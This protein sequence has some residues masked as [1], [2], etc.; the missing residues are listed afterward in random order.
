MDQNG[1]TG[2][3]AA[4]RLL[5]SEP[6]GRVADLEGRRHRQS[7]LLKTVLKQQIRIRGMRY[8]DI[9]DQ[10]G[11]SVMT[12]KRY[13][14]SERVPVEVL[15]DIG[16][17]LGLGLLELAEIAKADDCGDALDLELQQETEL[18]A[19]YALALMRLLLY[20]GMTV[21]EIMEEY[22]ID[23][24][25]VVRLLARLDRLKL[26]ELLPGNRVRIRGTRHVEWRP[27]GPIRRTIEN[28]IRKNFVAMDFANTEEFFGYESVRL[29]KSSIRQLEGH[30]RNL[31]RQVRTLHR[32]DQGATG[33]EK[34]WYTLLVAQR[35]TN[36]GF[37]VNQGRRLIPRSRGGPAYPSLPATLSPDGVGEGLDQN[38]PG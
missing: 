6:H 18:A 9:A 11:V 27:G 16:A 4:S 31:V 14:N 26:I 19:D 20:S 21:P 5:P 22:E 28:D 23:E 3:A 15:E 13:L 2:V 36:W 12:V 38:E 7:K 24:P 29:T 8:K 1:A 32:I 33:E 34:Q 30:M 37:P 25:T 35:E 10:L 17:C